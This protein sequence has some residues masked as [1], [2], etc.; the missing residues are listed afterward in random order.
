[1]QAGVKFPPVTVFYD[2]SDYWLADG[3]HRRNA[4]FSAELAQMECDVRQGTREDAQWYS[5]SANKTN[6]LRRTNA[7]KQRAVQAA[8]VHPGG[9]G[10]SD[11]QIAKHVGVD[12]KTVLGW[13]AKLELSKEIPQIAS[14]TVTR[15]QSTYQQNTSNIGR[16]PVEPSVPPPPIAPAITEAPRPVPVETAKAE[17][18]AAQPK[19]AEP[20][21]PAVEAAKPA[22]VS[23]PPVERVE[24]IRA[25]HVPATAPIAALY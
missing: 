17:P 4:A 1:V 11:H 15:G 12:Q 3:F 9:A 13:R 8:L 24:P 6:G 22:P 16:K 19:E 14:R 5:L 25:L 21:P 18:S 2:G 20:M 10:K 7:D 23:L